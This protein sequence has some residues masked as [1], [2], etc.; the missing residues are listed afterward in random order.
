MMKYDAKGDTPYMMNDYAAVTEGLAPRRSVQ[1]PIFDRTLTTEVVGDF[2]LPDYQPEIKRLLRI[3][4][5]VLPPNRFAG[6]SGMELGGTLDYFV[7]Y[8]GHDNQLYCAPLSAEY[9]LEASPGEEGRGGMSS[10][11]EPMVCTCDT[12]TEMPIGRVTAPRRLNI[13]CRLKT[14]VKLY[15]ECPLNVDGGAEGD[16]DETVEKLTGEAEVGRLYWGL[17]DTLPLQ[18]DVIPIPGENGV[19]AGTEWRVVCAEGQVMITEAAAAESLVSCRGEVTVKLTLCPA[20]SLEVFASDATV[21]QEAPPLTI[22]RRKIPFA[23]TVELE[24]VTP[25]CTAAACGY[26]TEISVQMEEGHIHLD[27]GVVS[28][29]RAQRNETVPY[30]KDLYS[31]RHESTCRHTTYPTER[32]S[33]ALNGNFTLSDSLPLTDVGIEPTARITD[34]TATAIPES[35]VSDAAKGRCVLNG[36]CRC[37]LLLLRD[38]EYAAA[39]MELPFRYEFEDS[40][41]GRCEDS[42]EAD[43]SAAMDFDGAVTVIHCRARMDG[44]RLG[45]DAE[46]A[47]AIRTHRKAAIS[48][49]CEVTAGDSV[50]RRRGEYVVCFPAPGDSVWSVAKRYHAPIAALTAANGLTASSPADAPASLEGVNYLIV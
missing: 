49:L 18:D 29:V 17:S 25:A 2:S 9:R 26:C 27:L 13:R 20:E 11:G 3:G 23:Q 33:R 6:S 39:D 28:E 5:N 15:G 32:A 44:E 12:V 48:A 7:L 8:M 19:P 46:L 1:L 42:G 38:G 21:E 4:V 40:S 14:D 41:L 35:L 31:T 10:V 47:V 36:T 22:L 43:G 16:R 37:H 45:V 30:I 34:V 50:T 24:G